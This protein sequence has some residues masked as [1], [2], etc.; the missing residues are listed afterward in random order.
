LNWSQSKLA[1]IASVARKTVTDF[2]A[3]A[4]P[5]SYR[6]RRD[7]TLALEGSGI[8]FVWP[9]GGEGVILKARGAG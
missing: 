5:I 3:E 1:Q 4:R 7:L 2:E 6:T 8:E 9:I